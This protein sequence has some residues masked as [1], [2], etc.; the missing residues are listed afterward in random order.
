[1]HMHKSRVK[2]TYSEGHDVFLLKNNLLSPVTSN[3]PV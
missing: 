2:A 3:D 1:M